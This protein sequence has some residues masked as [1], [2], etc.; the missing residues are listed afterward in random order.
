MYNIENLFNS[1]YSDRILLLCH[2]AITFYCFFKG[3]SSVWS[4]LCQNSGMAVRWIRWHVRAASS[5]C[6]QGCTA[7]AIGP[8]WG[9]RL[10]WHVFP[11]PLRRYTWQYCIW[12]FF[13]RCL[14]PVAYITLFNYVYR[15]RTLLLFILHYM[16]RPQWVIFRCSIYRRRI[17]VYTHTSASMGQEKWV[18]AQNSNSVLYIEHL[19]MTRW[20]RNM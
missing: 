11:V 10:W 9:N 18:N 1:W 17:G 20:G 7:A 3:W 5:I 16:F 2:I 15:L 19:K 12:A 14:H 6:P 13:P 4:I 8:S